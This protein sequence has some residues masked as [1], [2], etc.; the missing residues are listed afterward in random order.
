MINIFKNLIYK[1]S[2]EPVIKIEKNDS[3]VKAGYGY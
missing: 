1:K 2:G 3:Q